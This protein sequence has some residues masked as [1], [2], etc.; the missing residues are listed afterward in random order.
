MK[1]TT[2]ALLA[3]AL[4]CTACVNSSAPKPGEEAVNSDAEK[5]F[6]SQLSLIESAFQK[7]DSKKACDLQA[8]LSQKPD[9]PENISSESIQTLKEFQAK[10]LQAL[11]SDFK[12]FL[13]E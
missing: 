11:S 13:K 4:S 3:L 7:G 9:F 6:S 8:K 12:G 2:I 10:C 5:E 1:T